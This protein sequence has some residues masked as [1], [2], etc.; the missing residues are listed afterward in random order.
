MSQDPS[1]PL[2]VAV[3]AHPSELFTAASWADLVRTAERGSAP[4]RTAVA[5]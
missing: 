2:H 5:P 3:G 4:A 1:A